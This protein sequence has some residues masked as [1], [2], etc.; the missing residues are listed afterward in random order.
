MKLA[1]KMF[2][3]LPIWEFE[4]DD[5]G[6]ARKLIEVASQPESKLPLIELKITRVDLAGINLHLGYNKP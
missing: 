6:G 2:D 1:Y 5:S 4:E 3:D